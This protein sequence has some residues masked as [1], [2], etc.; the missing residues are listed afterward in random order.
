MTGRTQFGFCRCG[1]LH[2]PLHS[3]GPIA[4]FD[5][6]RDPTEL[7]NLRD[8]DPARVDELSELLNEYLEQWTAPEE[9]G[10]GTSAIDEALRAELEALGY[11]EDTN[12]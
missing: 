6:E 11:V 9:S 2:R 7:D 3:F 8:V 1:Q 4:L 12:P 10:A 5:L